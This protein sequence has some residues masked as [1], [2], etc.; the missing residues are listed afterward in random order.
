MSNAVG[1]DF[2]YGQEQVACCFTNG[3]IATSWL[4][5]AMREQ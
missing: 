1:D 3:R 5:S 2:S 4:S